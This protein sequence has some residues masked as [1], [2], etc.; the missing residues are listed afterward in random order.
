M[1]IKAWATV[2][3]IGIFGI[4][5]AKIAAPVVVPFIKDKKNHPIWGINDT[6]DFSY[7]NMAF[8]NS[9]H[10]LLKKDA[11]EYKTT[12]NTNDETLEKLEGFQWRRRE[13]VDGKYVSFRITW[14]K[15]D[16]SKGK[17][18]FYIGWTM[19]ETPGFGLSFVQLRAAWYEWL[20]GLTLIVAPIWFLV[21]KY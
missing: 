8:R 10:N 9:A 14:G 16:G 3:G 19:N 4:L 1:N 15:P 21:D 7:W 20:I 6:T 11:V 12:G 5:P 18:E 17:K 2:F 13:S